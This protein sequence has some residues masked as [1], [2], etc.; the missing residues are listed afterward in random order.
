M[1]IILT[2]AVLLFAGVPLLA[3]TL[4]GKARVVDGDTIVISGHR[5]RLHGIDSPEFK[6]TCV[7]NGQRWPCGQ[8]ATRYLVQLIGTGLVTCTQRDKDRYGRI[9]AVCTVAGNDLSAAMV[10]AGFGLAYRQ[11]SDDYLPQ[12]EQAIAAG[13]GMWAGEFVEP[14]DWR[15]GFRLKS[16]S[17]TPSPS[18]KA[19]AASAAKPTPCL[20]KGNISKSGRI[21]HVPGSRFYSRTKIDESAGERWFCTEDEARTAGWRAPRS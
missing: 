11:Y 20:I 12:Q 9:V 16:V 8:E 1:R 3:Q 13:V 17:A 14:W 7:R 21:Y 15:R 5:V 4:S 18:Q 10:A 2:L 6:Q 19:A